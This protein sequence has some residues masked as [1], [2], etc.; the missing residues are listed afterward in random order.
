M[1][2]LKESGIQNVTFYFDKIDDIY[3]YLVEKF[4]SALKQDIALVDEIKQPYTILEIIRHYHNIF[5]NL[6][7]EVLRYF[8][9]S[10]NGIVLTNYNK[11]V[12]VTIEKVDE[13]N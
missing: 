4:K 3:D 5:E 6:Q 7:I 10:E 8:V 2:T 13:K 1:Y 12:S 11:S 9:D